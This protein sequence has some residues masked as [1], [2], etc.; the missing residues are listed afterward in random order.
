MKRE[1][2]ATMPGPEVARPADA[3]APPPQEEDRKLDFF[4]QTLR[5]M[6]ASGIPFLVGG[7]WAFAR[8]T[9]IDRQRKDLDL[10]VLPRDVTRVMDAL[11]RAGYRTTMRFTHWLGKA[12]QGEDFVDVIFS[13]GNGLCTVDDG[14]FEHA[15]E[16]DVL[17]MTVRLCAP[18]EMIWSKAFVMERER[19]DGADVAH[20]IHAR[21]KTMDWA[22]LL[23]RFQRHWR[24]LFSHLILFG[25]IY[26]T[27]RSCIPDWLQR[28]LVRRLHGE[29]DSAPTPERLC[30]GTLLSWS[31]Y[32]IN[33][34]QWGYKDARHPPQGNLTSA[35][36]ERLTTT[37]KKSA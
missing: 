16:A 11:G 31:Q 2:Q 9:G 24:V 17:G 33:V 26:P 12:Y 19:Y 30:Q 3:T 6:Q 37:L 32:L 22:R 27:E 5:V 1:R 15:E 35:E 18:E 7:G 34:E 10:F 28:E 25:F 23:R 36:T 21:G 29:M 8:Q 14:W 4:R 20:L 13:S